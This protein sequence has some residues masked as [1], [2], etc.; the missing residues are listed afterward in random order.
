MFW[1][2]LVMI[3]GLYS[4][5]FFVTIAYYWARFIMVEWH[6]NRMEDRICPCDCHDDEV[7]DARDV[8]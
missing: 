5:V 2:L 8:A 6:I 4:M 3:I 1:Q 7:T